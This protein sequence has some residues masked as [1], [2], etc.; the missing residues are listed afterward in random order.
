MPHPDHTDTPRFSI[1]IPVYKVRAYLRE[2][3]DSILEQ[4]F[5]D[6]EVIA[7][8]DQSPDGCGAIL[9]EYAA[10]DGRISPVHLEVNGGIGN[11]RNEGVARAQ[12]K[13]ILF[14]DS[15]D[16]LMPGALRKMDA[17]I[18]ATG[19]PEILI[20]DYARTFWW[21]ASVRNRDALLLSEKGPDVFPVAE[22]PELLDMFTVVW[23]KAYRRDFFLDGGFSFPHG[24]YEDVVVVYESLMTAQQIAVLDQVCVRYRQRRQGSA[25]RSPNREHFAVFAQYER[26][27]SFIQERP[28]LHRWRAFMFGHMIDHYV[29]IMGREDRVP[30]SS[31]PEF[32]QRAAEHY[33]RYKPLGLTRPKGRLGT[34]MRILELSS[35]AAYRALSAASKNGP[36][37]KRRLRKV[38]SVVGRRAYSGLYRYHRSRP[39]D[40]NLAV[41]AAYWNRGANCNP[42]A[43]HDKVAEIVPH[44]R[45]VWIVK[46][47][48]VETIPQGL[49]YAVVNTPRYWEVMARAKY[50]VNNVNFANGIVKRPGQIHLQTHHGTPLKKMGIDQQNYPAAAKGMSFAR[51]LA[52]VDKWDLSLSSNRHSTE[53][54][55]RTY[56]SEF[57]SVE[58]GYPRNDVYYSATAGDVLDIRER[59]GIAPG[60]TVVLYAPTV[61]DYQKGFTP[62]LDLERLTRELGPGFVLLVRAHYFY[63]ADERLRQLERTGSII[64][65]SQ[66][67][68]IEELC[69]ASDALITD[70]SSIMFDYANLDR[71]I[72]IYAPD[73]E[74][75]TASRGVYF[76]LLSGAPGDS[77]GALATTAEELSRVFAS[78]AWNSPESAKLRAAFRERFCPFDDGY[79][80]ER[81]VRQV[82]LGE[83]AKPPIIPLDERLPAPAPS[84][85]LLPGAPSTLGAPPA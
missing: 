49:E 64:D 11:A 61:R 62:L 14:L 10:T 70:Y 39:I 2:C 65:G 12:G 75:Y 9:D 67:P 84:A 29:F 34:R 32:F 85:T 58:S 33:R 38:K 74:V 15:D 44:I 46:P 19:S 30:A 71:P 17:R 68:R 57:T 4:D 47:D 36:K 52:R 72:V 56:P 16:S 41:Y 18:K 54:W 8:N 20:Y 45:G 73:W 50:L 80:A 53:I 40:E 13:Y 6:F 77:P 63:Q 60:K 51:L 76:D 28:D 66:H 48:A 79:A 21:E 35:Y 55:E 25:L 42:L 7:V 22:R 5:T 27:F 1:V 43:I 59:L 24:Y 31:R 3:L 37:V 78:G 69:L 23:N 26:L 81:V 82:F 83:Q